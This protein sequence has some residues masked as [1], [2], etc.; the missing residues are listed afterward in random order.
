MS[1]PDRLAAVVEDFAAMGPQDRLELLLEYADGLPDLPERYR[2]H[3]ELL[4]RVPECQTPLFLAV[5]AGAG[6]EDPVHLF[7]SAPREAPT[8]R[9]FAAILHA[10]LDGESATA[11]LDVP[12]GVLDE[13]RLGEVVSPL[14]MRGMSSML[15]RIQRQVR[16]ARA[17]RD[18]TPPG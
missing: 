6:P 7:F 13:L 5:E 4:E 9:G 15:A 14:R 10:G 18:L 2:E 11:V 16:A 8:T 12:A 3:P 17:R 1:L